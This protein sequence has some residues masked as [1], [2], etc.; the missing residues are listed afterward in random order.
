M[1]TTTLRRAL[2]A[3]VAAISVATLTPIAKAADPYSAPAA[4]TNVVAYPSTY[5]V[6]VRWTA[7]P[8]VKPAIEG[9]IVSGGVGSC[10]VF[11]PA[12]KHTVALLP[13]VKG[14]TTVA[15]TVQAVNS[16]G[17]SAAAKAD[18][19]YAVS[20][21]TKTTIRDKYVSL[22]FLQLSDLHG[23]LEASSTS[24]GVAS[25]AGAWAADRKANPNTLSLSSGDNIGAAPQISSAFEE[26]P[27]IESLNLMKLDASTFGNHEH[28][29]T[30][31]HVQ[32]VIGASDFQWIV[33]N[34]SSLTD[35]KSGSKAAKSYKIFTLGGV[36]VGVVG[37]NT[38]T[39]KEQV[40]PGNLKG[41]SGEIAISPTADGVNAAIVAAKKEGAQVIVALVHQGWTEN[42]DGAV[43]GR[44]FDWVDQIKGANIIYGG[45]SHQTYNSYNPGVK[46]GTDVIIAET[47]NAGVEYTRTTTCFNTETKKVV[48]SATEYIG[49]SAV[50]SVTPDAAT[51]ALVK[52]YKDQLAPKLDVTIGKVS[53]VFPRG[54]TPAVER[55][56]ET[57]LGNFTADAVRA[58]Y[59][60]DFVLVNGGGIRDSFPAKTYVPLNTALVRPATGVTTGTFDVTFGD[61]LTIFPFGNSVATTT[62]TGATLWKALE[63]GVGGA[64]P[65]DG[66]FPQ[67]SGFKFSFDSTKPIGSRVVSVTKLDGTAIAADS[68]KYTI[69]TLDYIVYGGD[70]YVGV[71]S[72]K[73]S[74]IR[75]LYVDVFID[76]V[77]AATAGGKVLAVPAAD[78]RTKKVA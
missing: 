65:A 46:P 78:G 72:P 44:L 49:K 70:G 52:K 11:V 53:G 60:T 12:T 62:I 48:S 55:S 38:E 13:V 18:K 69:A 57:P 4:P 40:F 77:K 54:G 25:L 35:L 61:A 63:N 5:G 6:T 74:A 68:T 15:P 56:G 30:I 24:I 8:S 58:K 23:A 73:E 1:K 43:Q 41:A 27:T 51:A 67:I 20:T 33:S 75:D 32:K 39:T 9:Y 36:K 14:Q 10:P 17:F 71:F 42:I 2:I 47:R 34:Y 76:A 3:A 45:H 19:T 29:R 66:R 50:A 16:Y 21:L 59:K 28:D 37:A 31:D 7:S 22:Q 64:Y 26:I